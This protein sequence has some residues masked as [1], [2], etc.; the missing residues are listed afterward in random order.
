MDR[1]QCAAL[2]ALVGAGA[3]WV[4]WSRGGPAEP[5]PTP[6]DVAWSDIGYDPYAWWRSHSPDAWK[7]SYP[8][9]TMPTTAP[10]PLMAAESALSTAAA[11]NDGSQ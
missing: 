9:V 4:L 6:L 3:V 1:H 10:A 5:P 11:V 2:L 7:R 8:D